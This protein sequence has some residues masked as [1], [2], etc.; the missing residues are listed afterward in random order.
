[1]LLLWRRLVFALTV[2]R[3]DGLLEPLEI[4]PL[5][6]GFFSFIRNTY[7]TCGKDSVC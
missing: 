1:V 2:D 5:K 3:A 6:S 4:K 7:V